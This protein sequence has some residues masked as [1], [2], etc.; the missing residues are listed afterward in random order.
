MTRLRLVSSTI[1]P[2]LN[3]GTAT[4]VDEIGRLLID[5]DTEVV[6]VS[7]GDITHLRAAD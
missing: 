1:R 6:T 5:T 4:Q 3:V 2:P 7:A